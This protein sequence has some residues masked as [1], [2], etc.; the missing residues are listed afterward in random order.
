MLPVGTPWAS[1]ALLICTSTMAKGFARNRSLRLCQTRIK[2]EVVLL[3]PPV[4]HW[5]S[6]RHSFY[7]CSSCASLGWLPSLSAQP[8]EVA[9]DTWYLVLEDLMLRSQS[10]EI[11]ARD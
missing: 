10:L 3:P 6:Q 4:S 7:T 8:C 1:Q 5:E 9:G 11:Y 2:N